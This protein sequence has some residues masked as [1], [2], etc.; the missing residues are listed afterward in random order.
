MNDDADALQQRLRLDSDRC[1]A[2][3]DAVVTH[4]KDEAV[5]LAA[6]KLSESMLERIGLLR[7]SIKTEG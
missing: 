2:F 5:M 4:A 3:Y 7:D 1:F 6:Q